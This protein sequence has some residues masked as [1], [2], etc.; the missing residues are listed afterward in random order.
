VHFTIT[1][2]IGH[3]YQYRWMPDTA[4]TDWQTYA[5]MRGIAD[6]GVYNAAAAHMNR[7]HEVFAED[8]RFL[9]GG[10]LSNASGTLENPDLAV[11]TAVAGLEEFV[12]GLRESRRAAA[13]RLFPVPNP[14]NPSTEIRVQ[15]EEQRPRDV[16]VGVFD[17]HGR[18]VRRLWSGLISARE[19]R[20]PW[21]GR[22]DEGTP[23]G[24]GVYFA[25]LEYDGTSTTAKLL[26]VK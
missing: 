23:A 18:L 22:G 2:E 21:D 24:T 19:M 6:R 8:F 9:F 10:R 25:R 20:L 13:A 3:I 4:L 12:L 1:H 26:L 17:A 15:F 11:P 5:E 7:P 16:R 14:F